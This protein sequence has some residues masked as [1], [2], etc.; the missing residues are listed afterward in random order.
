MA[1]VT[2]VRSELA[3]ESECRTDMVG[4]SCRSKLQDL[5]DTRSQGYPGG[6]LVRIHSA[7]EAS[8]LKP[9]K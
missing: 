4:A 8:D 1:V 9:D 7:A 3:R 2:E 6:T 5:H